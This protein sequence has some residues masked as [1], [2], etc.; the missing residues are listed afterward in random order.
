MSSFL[1]RRRKINR[2]STTS[3]S[4][5]NTTTNSDPY[6]FDDHD[7]HDSLPPVP[8]RS[9]KKILYSKKKIAPGTQS[10]PTQSKQPIKKKKKKKRKKK[11]EITDEARR[12]LLNAMRKAK[13]DSLAIER[14]HLANMAKLRST[15]Q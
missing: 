11:N 9:M 13:A 15:K 7:D 3:D 1:K 10:K 6:A 2:A 8:L 4:S 12:K 5:K 14:Q